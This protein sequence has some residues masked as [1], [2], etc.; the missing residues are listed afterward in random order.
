VGDLVGIVS[1]SERRGRESIDSEIRV[2]SLRELFDACREAP[3]SRVVK[4]CLRGSE[5]EVWLNFA[6]FLRKP[7]VAP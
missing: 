1:I 3:A 5:G 4:V 7:E 2:R 6:S